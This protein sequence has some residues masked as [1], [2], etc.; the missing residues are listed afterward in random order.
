MIPVAKPVLGEEEAAAARRAILSGWVTQ[1]P[2]V[3]AFEHEWAELV[4]APHACAVS[5]CT[6]GLHLALLVADI[7]PGDEVITVSHS[8]I[9]TVNAVRNAG[10]LPIMVDIEPETFNISPHR[11]IDAITPKSKAILAVH[12][13]GMPCDIVSLKRI[14][15]EN[16]LVLIE[17]AACAIGSEILTEGEWKFIGPPH[18]DIACFS[19]HP[20]KV[21]TTGDGGMITTANPE[22]DAKLRLLRQHGMSI[23]DK[24]RHHAKSVMFESYPIPGFNYRMTDVQAAMGREQLKRLPGI[25]ERR[26]EIAARYHSELRGVTLPHQ[27]PWAR[28][29]WQSYAIQ[30][31]TAHDQQAIMQS[32]L[33]DGIATRRGVMCSHREQACADLPLR[34]HLSASEHAQ[35]HTII[36]P[37]Y[38]QMTDAEQDRVITSLHK[39]IQS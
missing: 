15:S 2:E 24:A 31:S 13:L 7:Q 21:I 9:A 23:S 30:L 35:D 17:D 11:V 4:G 14:A 25:L 38:P 36:L 1:G 37:L 32:M 16:N 10:A 18:A 3:E 20:R 29:N 6:T 27:P 8:Y 39:A 28:S 34:H 12:Q 26:R 33:D 22:W 5:N 19:L